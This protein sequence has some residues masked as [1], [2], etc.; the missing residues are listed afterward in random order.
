MKTIKITDYKQGR[1]LKNR[2]VRNQG[3]IIQWMFLIIVVLIV[4]IVIIMDQRQD[5]QTVVDN[6]PRAEVEAAEVVEIP[7]PV[8]NGTKEFGQIQD[9]RVEKIQNYLAGYGSPEPTLAKVIVSE[10]D[11]HGVDPY[12]ITAIFC[13][14]SSCGKVCSNN[15]CTG[16]GITDS[17]HIG[18]TGF[19]SKSE[20]LAHM[21]AKF[22]S[23]W[24]GYYKNCGTNIRCISRLYNP[25]ESWV[26]NVHYFYTEINK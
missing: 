18:K 6:Q 17:Q 1:L 3:K 13:Q 22:S 10:S 15:N 23:D 25:R 7:N 11:K 24:D 2:I 14:E 8:D 26:Q 20:G 12:I 4:A 16:Y 5:L 19:N 21:I 9:N